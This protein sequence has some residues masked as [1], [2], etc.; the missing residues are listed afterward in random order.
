M[1]IAELRVTPV[2]FA[3]PPLRNSTGVHEPYAIRTIVQ[4]RT[5]EG[6]EGA[7]ETYGGQ[8][9]VEGIEAARPLVIGQSPTRLE[10]MRMAIRDPHV[11]SPIEVAC[12]D[13]TGKAM[14]LSVSELL[15]GPIRNQVEF[16]AYLFYKY[17]D[18]NDDWGR[19]MDPEAMLREAKRFHRTWGFKCHKLKGGVLKPEEE[20]ETLRMLREH[21]GDSHQ[22]RIDPNGVWAVGTSIRMGKAMAQYNMEYLEDPCSG[23]AQMAEVRENVPV[24]L[25]T[26][27][28]VTAWSHFPEAVELGPVDVVLSD[29][30]YWGGLVATKYLG[31]VCEVLGLGVSMHSNSHLGVSLAAMLH[32]AA[33]TPQITYACDS[34]YPWVKEDVIRGEMF[35]FQDGCL[36][37][38][39]GPGLGVEIDPEKLGRLHEKYLRAK[40]A[41]RDDQRLIRTYEP[42]WVNRFPRW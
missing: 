26:N 16:S 19:V 5:D 34:H 33:V 23:M 15:G 18:E 12:L 4:V 29:H 30:H 39:R 20:L 22:L 11:Y 32:A 21:F 27:G 13:I 25:S 1:K 42:N 3:D 10:C 6:L 7:G 36:D 40:Q 38:P 28:V 2:A 35:R 17:E 14:G 31:H 41:R 9:I 37:V 8:S 24:P